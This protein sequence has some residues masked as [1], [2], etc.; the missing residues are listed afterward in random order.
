MNRWIGIIVAAQ[1]ILLS[2]TALDIEY[3][4]P[5]KKYDARI[6]SI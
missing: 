2:G 5:K 1:D 3:Y 4:L 6:F